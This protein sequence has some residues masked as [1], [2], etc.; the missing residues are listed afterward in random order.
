MAKRKL[1]KIWKIGGIAF[2]GIVVLLIAVP[3]FLEAKIADIVK[4]KANQNMNATLDFED[5]KLSLI[6]SFPSA[7]VKLTGVALVNKAPFEGDTLFSA[8]D[9][10]LELAIK[11]LF[12]SAEDPIGIKKFLVDKAK[13]HIKVDAEENANYNIALEDSEATAPSQ[14]STDTEGFTLAL[15]DYS[16]TNTVIIYDDFATGMHLE[17]LEMNHSGS[18]DLSLA[19]SQLQTKTDALVSFALDSTRYLNRNKLALDAL[20]GIDLAK[21]KYSFLDNKALVNQLPLV[22]DGFVQVN[23]ADQEVDFSFKTPSSDFKNFLAVIPEAYASNLD[24][25]ATT[26]N[27]EVE[28]QFKGKVDDTHIPTFAIN[29]NSDNASFKYPDLPK[30][31]RNIFIATEIKNETGIAEDT[32]VN[33]DR[34]SFQ[35]DEDVFNLRAKIRELLG[36][37]KVNLHADGRID[38]ANIAQAYPVPEDHGLQGILNA[39]ITTAFDRTSIEQQHYHNTSITGTASLFGF[40]YESEELKHPVDI[41]EAAVRFDPSTV[42]LDAFSGKTGQ[43]DFQTTGT[44]DNLLGYAFND[45]TLK[46]NFQLQSNRLVLDDFMVEEVVE[47][48]ADGTEKEAPQEKAERIQIPSFLEASIA[49][50]ANT[51]QYDN[52]NLNNVKGELLIKDQTATLKDVNADLFDGRVTLN[53]DVNTKEA[54]STFAMDL[55]MDNFK[56]AESFQALDLFKVVAPVAQALQGRLNSNIKLSGNLKEDL[57]PNLATLTGDLLGE[58]LSTKVNTQ[59]APALAALSNQFDFIDLNAL[60][61]K[62]L[63]AVLAFDEGKVATQP[64]TVNYK[65]IAITIAG[66]HS[67]DALLDYKATLEV[68]AKYLGEEVNQLIAQID[69]DSLEDLTVPVIASIGGQYTSPKVST[70]LTAGV[71]KLTAQ[72]VDI[73]KQKLLDQGKDKAKDLIGGLLGGHAKDSTATKSSGVTDVL[74]S[75]LGKKKDSTTKDSTAKNDAVKDAAKSVLG[76]LLKKK[77]D[78]TKKD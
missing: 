65:D 29:I 68:P 52:L 70:D 78:T 69:D 76:G 8:A 23:E 44:L 49:A 64:F 27:F 24:G 28:G 3:F 38:L 41:T 55:G 57:T 18:G 40:H 42:T 16:I 25:V 13:L 17:V 71:K 63:K 58:L 2:L 10:Q 20:I 54:V 46:G 22:F 74:G 53:G 15:Q 50:T 21:N 67:F 19:T 56:I 43:T 30:T 5:A 39:D 32:Y 14:S 66:N 6:K 9:I 59:K 12:K 60:D 75:L 7:H 48:G 62:D 47:E 4:N 11:E 31:V 61:L 72:L 35:I 34:L 37:T 36:N 73:Q 26:G 77:K 33:I 51:V 45:E 1:G